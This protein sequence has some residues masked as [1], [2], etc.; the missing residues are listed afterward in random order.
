MLLAGRSPSGPSF[1]TVQLTPTSY[2]NE[3]VNAGVDLGLSLSPPLCV[4]SVAPDP[5]MGMQASLAALEADSHAARLAHAKREQSDKSTVGTYKRHVDR[6]EKWWIRYQAEQ[7]A[8]IKGWTPIPAFPITTAKVSMFLGHESKWE[9]VHIPLMHLLTSP[10]Q[11]YLSSKRQA[12]RRQ[13]Q[14]QVSAKSPFRR[15]YP[16]SNT[17]VSTMRTST[18]MCLMRRPHYVLIIG[19]R[20]SRRRRSMTSRNE[21]KAH[22]RSRQLAAHQVSRH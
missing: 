12:E 9:K 16:P 4:M 7:S 1:P 13:Y 15:P 22:K 2:A 8:S 17:G 6:Y 20:P 10:S 14:A 19:S 18:E 21:S 3:P 11:I 5:P